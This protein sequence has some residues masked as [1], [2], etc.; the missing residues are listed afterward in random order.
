[1]C[2]RC[3]ERAPILSVVFSGTFRF[4]PRATPRKAVAE[5]QLFITLSLSVVLRFSEEQLDTDALD[6]DQY[7]TIL[8][9]AFFSAPS[10]RRGG[11]SSHGRRRRRVWPPLYDRTLV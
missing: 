2:L 5:A 4:N 8:V 10:V 6:E 7:G 3:V 1:M 11:S 9:V